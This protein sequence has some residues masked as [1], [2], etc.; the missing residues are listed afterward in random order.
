VPDSTVASG[1]HAGKAVGSEFVD[2]IIDYLLPVGA[3]VAGFFVGD[4][5]LGGPASVTNAISAA[6]SSLDLTTASAVRIGGAI[7]ALIWGAVGYAFW[8]MGHRDGWIMRALGKGFGGFFLGTAANE[9]VYRVLL[10]SPGGS[11]G[12]VD[13]LFA[14]IQGVAQGG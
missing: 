13:K 3:G 4:A 12:L 2:V 9:F 14:G 8:R 5:I 11:N 6:A 10:A 7:F 1:I